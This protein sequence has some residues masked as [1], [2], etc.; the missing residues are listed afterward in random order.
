M[1]TGRRRMDSGTADS[2][3]QSFNK[4]IVVDDKLQDIYRDVFLPKGTIE[5]Q[6]RPVV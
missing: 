4:R 3:A 6:P 5:D 2:S 1:A